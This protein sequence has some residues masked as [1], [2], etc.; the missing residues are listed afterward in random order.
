MNSAIIVAAGA[1]KR[2]G[3]ATPKQFLEL[4]GKP[5]V[6]HTML[7]FEACPAVDEI[8][9][10][11]P[12]SHKAGFIEI[13]G[14]YPLKKLT[15]IIGGGSSRAESVLNGLK[16]V[17]PETVR[18]VAVHDGAR[19]LVTP[20]EIA[21]TIKKAE[22]TGAA[23]LTAPVTDTVKEISGGR[24]IRTVDRRSL[25]RALTPQC[26][27][28]DILKKAYEMA[29]DITEATDESYLVEKAGFPVTFVEGSPFN[30]KITHPEDLAL[31][32][33]IMERRF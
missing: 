5:V 7:R 21:E 4:K 2:F 17:R 12:D 11:L 20:D 1:S 30:I 22:E 32:E 24:I 27:R 23:V 6:I 3:G 19:P 29:G 15:R 31:A 16:A 9:L 28:Y 14:K 33:F 8:I 26:F 25:R 13:A 18:V 10:V